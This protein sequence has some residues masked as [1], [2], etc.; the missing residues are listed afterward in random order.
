MA[1]KILVTVICIVAVLFLLEL[2]LVLPGGK[3]KKE[4]EK[5]YHV[6]FAHRGLHTKDMSVPENSMAA[7]KAAVDAGYGIELDI[8]FSKDDQIVVFHDE[9]LNRVCGV[10]GR[11]DAFTYDELK[12]MGLSGT[13]EHIP[14]FSEVLELID[15]RVPLLVELKSC[16]KNKLLCEKALPM[17]RAYKGDFCI[18]S[19]SPI[20]VK[21]FRK[22]APDILRGQLSAPVDDFREYIPAFIAFILSRCFTNF[23]SRPHFISYNKV[24]PPMSV[25]LSEK[26]GAMRYVW[27]VRPADDIRTLEKINDAVIFEYYTPEAKY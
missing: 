14:L 20:I 7:F 23:L 3:L 10:D 12:K 19:F 16:R 6:N 18:E 1:L 4:S 26:L 2:F 25:R 27:T 24:K 21:W 17:L 22:N 5:F 13:D 15:G 9:T 8:Q 11:L